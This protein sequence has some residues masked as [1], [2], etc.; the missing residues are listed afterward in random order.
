MQELTAN[1]PP[2]KQYQQTRHNQAMKL[3]D[4]IYHDIQQES[5]RVETMTT[6]NKITLTTTSHT[7][8]D[9]RV[10]KNDQ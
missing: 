2:P 5:L 1:K 3:I 7:A 10:A 4:E 9:Q 6:P 8:T